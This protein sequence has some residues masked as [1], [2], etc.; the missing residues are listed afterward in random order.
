MINDSKRKKVI[1]DSLTFSRKLI[2]SEKSIVV[3]A[4]MSVPE[5]EIEDP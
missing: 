2:L 3:L 1:K 5:D 4:K